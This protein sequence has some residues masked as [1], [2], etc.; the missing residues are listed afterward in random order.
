MRQVEQFRRR[1]QHPFSFSEQALL[2]AG[3]GRRLRR[4]RLEYLRAVPVRGRA[5]RFV[6]FCLFC[7]LLMTLFARRLAAWR[8][9]CRWL[10][11]AAEALLLFS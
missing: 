11:A 10:F 1:K 6:S 3:S 8:V 4:S 9:L 7:L 2:A 5:F